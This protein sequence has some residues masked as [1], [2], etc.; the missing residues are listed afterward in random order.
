VH[1]FTPSWYTDQELTHHNRSVSP[2]ARR[3]QVCRKLD[4]PPLALPPV[5]DPDRLSGRRGTDLLEEVD[6]LSQWVAVDL[7]NQV[8]ALNARESGRRDDRTK[9]TV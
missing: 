2:G 7:Q 9:K 6:R 1:G 5:L 4:L 8:S 3:D